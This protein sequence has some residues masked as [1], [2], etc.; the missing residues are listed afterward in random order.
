MNVFER[1]FFTDPEIIQDPIPYYRAL[2]ERG[3]VVREPHKGVFMLSR[4]D[5]ILEI[6]YQLDITLVVTLATCDGDPLVAGRLG[7]LRGDEIGGRPCAPVV[8]RGSPER[9]PPAAAAPD[10]SAPVRDQ[11]SGLSPSRARAISWAHG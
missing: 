7:A 4:I 8:Q 10:R 6:Y 9:C 1:D 11:R 3:P 2:H 5:E